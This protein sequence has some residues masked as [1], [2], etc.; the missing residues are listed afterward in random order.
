MSNQDKK[1]YLGLAEIPCIGP[2][3]FNKL[4]KSFHSLEEAWSAPITKLEQLGFGEKCIAEFIRLRNEINLDKELEKHAKEGIQ[5]LTIEDKEYPKLL[6]EIYD[7]PHVLFY[8]GILPTDNDFLV[9]VVGSRKF[10]SY[11]K[12]ATEEIAR[13]LAKSGITVV[14]G[15]ALGIDS[16]A[17]KT[18]IESGG[19]TIAILGCGI[20]RQNIYPA[21]NMMLS[22]NIIQSGGC[23]ISEHPIGTPPYKSNFPQRN[24]IISGI[25]L[26]TLI[27]EAAE[28][29]GALI[30]AQCALEQNREVFAV[31][32]PITSQA[33]FGTNNLIK[34]G[35]HPTTSAQDILDSLNLKQAIDF[36][37]AREIT[38][39]SAQ[40]A[41][42]LKHLEREPKHIDEIIRLSKM[43]PQEVSS[44]LTLMEMKGKVKHLG[45]MKYALAR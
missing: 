5:I 32:G 8:R 41:I 28:K 24:R 12:Q 21:I 44:A 34:M 17:H 29:S 31:P 39:D 3:K 13:D 22:E 15:L 2:A 23:V 1:Y 25:S 30:T 19:K 16:I 33:S 6:K 7:P 35:A 11:G 10:T 36:T 26:G 42:L 43:K 27:V 20:E 9:A 37:I 38:P 14:S 18:T 45:G 40:E 4:N